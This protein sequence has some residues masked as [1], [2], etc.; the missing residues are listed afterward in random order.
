MDDKGLPW[1]GWHDGIISPL[2]HSCLHAR[3]VYHTNPVVMMMVEGMFAVAIAVPSISYVCVFCC[4]L[5]D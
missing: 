2:P 5:V 1:T 4:E 3:T